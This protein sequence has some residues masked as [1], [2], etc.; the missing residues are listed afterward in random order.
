LAWPSGFPFSV[1]LLIFDNR[2]CP[3]EHTGTSGTTL[4]LLY[5]TFYGSRR[6]VA[7]EYSFAAHDQTTIFPAIRLLPPDASPKGR[8]V[9]KIEASS[10]LIPNTLRI[11]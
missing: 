7:D 5:I 2:F 3:T 10:L 4:I 8:I 9:A 11:Y 6:I 1:R